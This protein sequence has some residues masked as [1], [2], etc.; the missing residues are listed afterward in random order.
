MRDKE[1]IDKTTDALNLLWKEHPDL[2]LGQLIDNLHSLNR[3]KTKSK[4]DIF[5]TEDVEWLDWL[6][7]LL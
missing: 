4:A 3:Q 1:R 5:Y 7:K 2:R 6:N